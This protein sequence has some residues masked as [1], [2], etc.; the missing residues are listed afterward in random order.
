MIHRNGKNI[1]EA[2]TL[3]LHFPEHITEAERHFVIDRLRE[4]IDD[5]SRELFDLVLFHRHVPKK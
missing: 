2:L 1:T 3:R 5:K 4:I